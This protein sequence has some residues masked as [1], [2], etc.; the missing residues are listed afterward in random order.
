MA[1]S[2]KKLLF[3]EP[4]D[5]AS[6][7]PMLDAITRKMCAAF[8]AATESNYAYGG[9]HICICGAYSSCTD[10]FLP[11]GTMT[12]SLCVHYVSHHRSSVPI[13]E[14]DFIARFPW[15]E[16]EP[17]EVELQGP[18]LQARQI[19][20]RVERSIDKVAMNLWQQW[21]LNRDLLCSLLLS[22]D[23]VERKGAED[24]LALL[25]FL[26]E[27]ISAIVRAFA[28]IKLDPHHWGGDAL[29][30]P[31]WDRSAWLSPMIQMLRSREN[32]P[33]K[34]RHLAFFFRALAMENV[35]V[36]KD[37]LLMN[38]TAQGEFKHAICIAIEA[39]SGK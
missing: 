10:H 39:L 16:A 28:E 29:R 6:T 26:S 31:N 37:L 4:L 7:I 21:G 27:P 35:L 23:S 15:G 9:I 18:Q 8:R 14:L 2:P 20:L 22:I 17:T 19:Q 3:I 5:A 30:L 1:S 25:R 32:D 34:A 13:D 24:L 36:P 33:N 38:D 11:D 12:N